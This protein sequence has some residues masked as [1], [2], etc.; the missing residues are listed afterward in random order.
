MR[1]NSQSIRHMSA[2]KKT[3]QFAKGAGIWTSAKGAPVAIDQAINQADK[4]RGLAFAITNEKPY[5]W[6]EVLPYFWLRDNCRCG[7]CINQDTR[8]RN[9]DTFELPE[10]IGPVRITTNEAGL[11][12]E[13]SHG[14]H[15]SFYRWDFLESYMKGARPEPDDVPFV[16]FGSE[17]HANSSIEIEYA[18]FF[19]DETHAVG[20]LTDRIKRNGYA[21]VIGVP[22]ESAKP[23]EDLLR[24]IGPI[25][26]THYG[27]FYDFTADM[28]YAD[29][30]YTNIPLALHTDNTYFTD[31]SGVQAFHLLSHTVAGSVKGSGSD[32]GGQSSLLDGFYAAHIMKE[33]APDLFE[34]L[35]NVGVPYHASGNKGIAIS[36]DELYPV[37]EYNTERNIM[38]RIR[39]NNDDRGV[40]FPGGKYSIMQWYKAAAKWR[41][42][43]A[44]KELVYW[45]QLKPGNLLLFNNYR[46]LHGR[47]A[48]VG[49][50]RIC[51]GYINY[52]DFISRWRNTNYPR[53]QVL[54]QVTG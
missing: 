40:V 32:L 36:P 9:F 19:K 27:G 38:H 52:D 21:V 26:E 34:V 51:G 13:W 47:S 22:T 42:I 12:I 8:Q 20:R 2:G 30:A 49:I 28:K 24:K 7:T 11:E 14:S 1:L 16:Y 44:R 41:E 23:T 15:I 48:F 46:L 18:E 17:G 10:D 5:R 29:T 3:P 37:L 39:W 31:P 33:E 6:G 4:S 53:D 43:L 35:A 45:F 50:R 54:K 25:R